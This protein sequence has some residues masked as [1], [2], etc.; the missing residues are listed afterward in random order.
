MGRQHAPAR[1]RA[2]VPAAAVAV[3]TS[4]S[5]DCAARPAAKTFVMP[6][7]PSPTTRG[8]TARRPPPHTASCVT[9]WCLQQWTCRSEQHVCTPAAGDSVCAAHMLWP[10]RHS[11][12]CDVA[13]LCLSCTGPLTCCCCFVSVL[14]QTSGLSAKQLRAEASALGM[15]CSWCLERSELL[16]VYKRAK[17]VRQTQHWPC[18]PP[19]PAFVDCCMLAAGVDDSG[20]CLSFLAIVDSLVWVVRLV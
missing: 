16:A 2:A 15:D 14:L 4:S 11:P 17:H 8:S 3:L 19:I 1:R 18:C 12:Y 10:V 7:G 9:H 13:S 6:A 5:T 20:C